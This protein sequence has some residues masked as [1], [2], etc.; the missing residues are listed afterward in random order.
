MVSA[1]PFLFVLI[2]RN[3]LHPRNHSSSV[4]IFLS[5]LH[6]SRC[7][8]GTMT[9]AKLRFATFEAYLAYSNQ[10]HL[11]G[12]YELIEG[13]LVALPP[14]SGLNDWLALNLRDLLI[15]T[16]FVRRTL[17]RVHTCEVQV[18]VL[19]PQDAANR[20][21]D[22]VVL[23]EE[24]LPLIQQRLTITLD[25]PPPR[26]V[27]EVVSPGKT[28]RD[29]DYVN[30]RAQYAGL[31]VEEYWIVDPKAQ[32]VLVLALENSSY[33][34]IGQFQGNDCIVSPTFPDLTLTPQQV[35]AE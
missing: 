28:N 9:Q 24:H 25:M 14:E 16:Q 34:E 15:A 8:A 11:E 7:G 21:P 29:R 3:L 32:T 6:D 30:K 33:Q 18:P 1:V 26:L 27:V 13:E 20:Y 2:G 35:F 4:I 10:H 12:Y 19:Q 23:R 17:V 31:H 22:L 5:R